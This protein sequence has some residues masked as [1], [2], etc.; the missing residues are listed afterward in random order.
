MDEEETVQ[1]LAMIDKKE[2]IRHITDHINFEEVAEEIYWKV[3]DYWKLMDEVF[4]RV[5]KRAKVTG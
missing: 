4:R 2:N 1:A 3:G 5:I